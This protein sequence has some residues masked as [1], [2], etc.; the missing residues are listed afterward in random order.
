MPLA[1]VNSENMMESSFVEILEGMGADKT[2]GKPRFCSAAH[3]YEPVASTPG[4]AISVDVTIE[5]WSDDKVRNL[6]TVS[7]YYKLKKGQSANIYGGLIV[8]SS[9]NVSY[10][11]KVENVNRK[12]CTNCVIFSQE[13]A[14]R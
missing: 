2:F 1:Q 14:A 9:G 8:F 13:V 4:A 12:H 6:Q 11:C 3:T 7:Y 10:M 5:V